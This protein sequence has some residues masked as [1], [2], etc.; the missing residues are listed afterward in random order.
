MPAPV[1]GQS[2]LEA[3]L[4][5][6]A[7]FLLLSLSS[8]ELGRAWAGQNVLWRWAALLTAPAGALFLAHLWGVACHLSGLALRSVRIVP[9]TSRRWWPDVV[10]HAGSLTL[11]GLLT[12][13]GQP[14]SRVCGL[15]WILWLT[16]NAM[17]WAAFAGARGPMKAV[18]TL[19][20]AAGAA[21]WVGGWIPGLVALATAHLFLVATTL[22]PG[23]RWNGPLVRS[24]ATSRKAVWLTI[25]DGPAADTEAMLDLL[26]ASNAR[27]TF[28]VIGQVAETRPDLLR[29]IA[30]AGH[31]LGNHTHTHPV[32]S[33]WMAG[34]RRTLR[35]I[36]LASAAIGKSAGVAPL[37]FRAPAGFRNVFLWPCLERRGMTL[38]GWARRGFDGIPCDPERVVD[39]LTRRMRPGDILLIHQGRAES[40]EVLRRLLERLDAAG[41]RCVLP[42]HP[43]GDWAEDLADAECREQECAAEVGGRDRPGVA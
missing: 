12:V 22:L 11:A 39:R 14:V 26:R 10:G 8:W 19:H 1:P 28:F 37:L 2:G 17:A 43:G 34:P 33:F 23:C 18:A 16:L 4:T 29:S 25:D 38:V 40:V 24:F 13:A 15:F 5:A 21:W 30:A 35:E 42:G 7:V 9:D 6:A 27:A 36:D 20:V 41:Y 3:G 31:G 32:G